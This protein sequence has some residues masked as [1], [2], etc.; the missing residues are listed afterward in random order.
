MSGGSAPETMRAFVACNLDVAS[1]RALAAQSRR[2]REQ[3]RAPAARWVAST[4]LHLTLKFLGPT[5]V[6]VAPA[7]VQELGAL[8][9]GLEPKGPRRAAIG[10]LS[11]F[12]SPAT[13]RV[14][15]ALVDDRSGELARVASAVEDRV[16]GL[17]FARDPRAFLPHVTLARYGEPVDATSWLASD[18]F[19]VPPATF[20]EMVLYRSDQARSGAEYTALARWALTNA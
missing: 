13:A 7:L 2:L 10:P 9:A 5:D 3:A 16:A 14:L 6:G 15:V 4:K 8:V 11:A 20:T 1:V 12:P 18:P 19:A 17:G